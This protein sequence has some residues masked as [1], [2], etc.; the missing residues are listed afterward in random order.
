MLSQGASLEWPPYIWFEV[1]VELT[2]DHA[3]CALCSEL[4]VVRVPVSSLAGLVLHG[5]DGR[6]LVENFTLATSD[7]AGADQG[8]DGDM[9]WENSTAAVTLVLLNVPRTWVQTETE[10]VGE[11]VDR[12]VMG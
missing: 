6:V 1:T 10:Y 8:L 12:Q 11:P 2:S 4:C 9:A 3:Q 5:A 7:T